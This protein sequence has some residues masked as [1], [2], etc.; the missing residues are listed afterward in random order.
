MSADR[1]A[2]SI[3]HAEGVDKVRA[4]Q[5]VLYR[6]AK[7]DPTRR[8]HALYDKV[9]RSDILWRAWVDVCT[10]GGA[11]GVDGVTIDAIAESGVAGVRAFLDE[12]AAQLQAGT[13]R[14][15]P[16][17]RVHIPKPDGRQR[18]LGIP[19]VCDR[20]VMTAAKI[21][22]EAIRVEA[23]RGADWVLDADIKACFDE[24]DHDALM[25]LVARRVSDRSMLKLLR[26]WLRAGVLEGGRLSDTVSGTPQGSP[27]SPLLANIALHRLDETWQREGRRLGV[28]VRYA[29]DF[30][31][32]CPTRARAEEAQRRVAMI[33]A[34]LGLQLNPDKTRIVCLTEGAEGFDF[35]GFHLHKVRH[36]KWKHR[37]YLQRWPSDRAMRTVRSRIRAATHRRFVGLDLSIVVERLNRS[38]RAWGAYFRYGN[39]SRKFSLI[40]SYVHERLAILASNKHGRRGRNWATHYTWAWCTRLGVYRLTGTVRHGTAHAWR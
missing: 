23:N 15:Q 39:S 10:N 1:S 8:F 7:Q 38:L 3:S 40:D 16:L 6:S 4:L 2:R 35:L 17:R 14:P 34:P 11:P 31:V 37:W 5:R 21:V 36:W 25:A 27:I 18:P 12:L 22:L 26:A 9:A 29:D 33:L 30:V 32:V 28:L 24:I 19:T 20:V 13:Y